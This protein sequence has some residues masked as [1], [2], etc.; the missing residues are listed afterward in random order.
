M[1]I[2]LWKTDF[3][4][5]WWK[6]VS[7]AGRFPAYF[8]SKHDNIWKYL[9]RGCYTGVTLKNKNATKFKLWCFWSAEFGFESPAVTLVSWS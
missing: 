8:G 4:C 2:H 7:F 1:T 5:D 6:S 3:L 9:F